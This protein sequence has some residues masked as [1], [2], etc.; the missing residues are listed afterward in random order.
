MQPPGT[1]APGPTA[2][3]RAALDQGRLAYQRCTACAT[4]FHRPRLLCPQCGATSHTWED[5]AGPGT[6]YSATTVHRP[7]RPHRAH[8][9]YQVALVDLDEG[10]RVMGRIHSR[11][12]APPPEA[13]IGDRVRFTPWTAP[14]G[15]T[16]IGFTPGVRR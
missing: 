13:A 15:S 8:A 16:Q 6:V 4:P 5:A 2:L 1:P 3:F 10:P 14:D 9:P 7:P 12:G 11:A